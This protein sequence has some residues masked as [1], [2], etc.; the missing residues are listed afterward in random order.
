MRDGFLPASLLVSSPLRTL[1]A[2]LTSSL[3]SAPFIGKAILPL[4]V[5]GERQ[6]WPAARSGRVADTASLW[7][8]LAS[9]REKCKY[10]A[11]SGH[12]KKQTRKKESNG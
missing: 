5:Q 4:P 9:M 12:G 11:H 1:A 3:P 7:E 8:S 10:G 6:G 2:M